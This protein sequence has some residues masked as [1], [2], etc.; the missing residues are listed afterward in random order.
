MHLVPNDWTEAKYI[1]SQLPRYIFRGHA[2]TNWE[3]TTSLERAAIRW[4]AYAHIEDAEAAMLR[5]FQRRAHHYG[6]DLP[7]KNDLVEWLALI[8]HYGGP[9][10][11]L[12]FTRSPYVAAFFAMENADRDATVFAIDTDALMT[13]A[14]NTYTFNTSDFNTKMLA[15]ANN[16]LQQRSRNTGLLWVEPDR[17]NQR[18]SVQQGTFLLPLDTARSFEDNM[19]E[20]FS[21]RSSMFSQMEPQK[22]TSYT[23]LDRAILVKIVLSRNF[24]SQAM[25]DLA[26]MNVTS[27]SLFGGLE[28][29]ARSLPGILREDDARFYHHMYVNQIFRQQGSRG[30]GGRK[31]HRGD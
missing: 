12:D 13:K 28:G 30:V 22:L 3:L 16:V 10:R 23:F 21:V 9:T 14:R 24:H 18:I 7:E 5:E 4:N 26:S 6:V 17:L 19:F 11:L 27:T 29:F 25:L 8:Q 1:L 15:E 31:E 2:E 20:D